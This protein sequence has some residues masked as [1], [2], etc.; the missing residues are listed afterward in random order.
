MPLV[1]L[2]VQNDIPPSD[3]HGVHSP[4]CGFRGRERFCLFARAV[5]GVDSGSYSHMQ[6]VEV[7]RGGGRDEVFCL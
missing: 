2:K 7:G 5:G 1:V 6:I 3:V 4:S